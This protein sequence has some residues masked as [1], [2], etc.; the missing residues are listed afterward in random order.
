M[1]WHPKI[2]KDLLAG[3]YEL[4]V[5]FYEQRIQ[6][7]PDI[8]SHYWYLGLAY[9]LT[10]QEEEAQATWL[11]A[12]AQ[13][14]SHVQESSANPNL[15]DILENEAQRQEQLQHAQMHCLIRHHIR[16]LAPDCL[17][18]LIRLVKVSI[19][20][21]N[22][23]PL[24]LQEWQLFQWLES[25]AFEEVDVTLLMR[26]LMQTMDYPSSEVMRF[27]QCCLPFIETSPHWVT[28]LLNAAI[29]VGDDYEQSHYAADLA[30]MCYKVAPD[31]IDVLRH[32][33]RYSSNIGHYSRALEIAQKF[34]DQAPTLALKFISNYQVLRIL[35]YSGSW[36]N[37]KPVIQ[38]HKNLLQEVLAL[39]ASQIDWDLKHALIPAIGFLSY[40]QDNLAEN[41]QFHHQLSHIFQQ[42]LPR[43]CKDNSQLIRTLTLTQ[44]PLKIGYIAHTFRCHSV[45]WLCRWLF[46]H[47][48]RSQFQIVIYFVNQSLKD[49]FFQTWFQDSVDAVRF[50][51][52]SAEEIANQIHQDEIDILVDLDSV[53]LNVT[54]E[55]MARKPA[56]IQVTW[57][58]WDATGLSTVD[59]FIADPYVLPENAP[60]FYQENILRLP[61]TYLAVDG[62]EVGIPTL[63]RQDLN[64]PSNAVIY[65]SAQTG[66][67]RHPNTIQLQMN[68]LKAVPNSYFLIKGIADE[69]T[70]QKLFF[71]LATE[72][73]VAVDRL[74]FLPR[75][76]NE[77]V[78][79][80]NLTIADVVLDTYPY[81]GA[82]TTLETLW[83][84]IPIVTRVGEQFSARNSYTFLVNAG[85]TEGIA[86]TDEEYVHW[87]VRLGQ[88]ETL[89]QKITWKLRQAKSKAP[90][91]NAKQFTLEMETAYRQMWE[92]Y[93]EKS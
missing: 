6:S 37:I 85:I 89:R 65:L 67:K 58:G 60:E 22:F 23:D 45:G 19:E 41:R 73:G 56:P 93:I 82:T 75:D 62:F 7:E 35:T 68:I 16:A 87:G 9:L 15:L 24:L 14:N 12:I 46:Q 74:R 77:Y 44:K 84:E 59:Y 78:H 80:A 63:N 53:S 76:P 42:D 34:Y 1:S 29:K 17:D 36:L 91:W 39:E 5:Q 18:N 61:Q 47:H 69:V 79:R 55:V 92:N 11:F 88:D 13:D 86:W 83:M 72:E 71:H 30:E 66:A 10:D 31:N 21:Q 52:I 43:L 25:A 40:L 57:L 20:V 70:L 28:V 8:L 50:C 54:Y 3:Q 38:H 32:L 51:G 81:N 4:V 90:L 2:I 48:D 27:A 64:I 49:D 26:V 33:S